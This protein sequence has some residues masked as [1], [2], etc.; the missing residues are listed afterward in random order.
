M[1]P[2][3]LKKNCKKCGKAF[4]TYELDKIYCTSTCE[5]QFKYNEHFGYQDKHK[6]NET[7]CDQCGDLLSVRGSVKMRFCN[8]FCK[9]QFDKEARAKKSMEKKLQET[10]K[11]KHKGK[12]L[13]YDVLNKMAEKKRV[14]EDHGWLYQNNRDRI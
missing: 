6:L 9:K 11:P 7:N 12:R 3:T 14:F 2:Q 4:F 10:E 8:E 5:A 13:P 1:A